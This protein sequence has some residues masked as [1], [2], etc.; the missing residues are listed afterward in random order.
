MAAR[1]IPVIHNVSSY[2]RLS[3]MARLVYSLGL[4]VLVATK[5]YGGAAQSGVPEVTRM[6]LKHGKSFIALPDLGDA[7]D[8]LKPDKVII[9]SREHAA[10][11]LDPSSIVAGDGVV[12]IVFNGGEPD[13][14]RAEA[15]LG[16]PVYIDGVA[17]RLGAISEAGIILYHALREAKKDKH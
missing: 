9:V 7:I 14:T 17:E 15:S 6:A 4:D 13:F 3:D 5:V 11:R 1:L 12:M 16:T 8:V 10:Q 2:Q